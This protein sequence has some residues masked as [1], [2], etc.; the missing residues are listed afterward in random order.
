MHYCKTL[1]FN[2]FSPQQNINISS[3][4]INFRNQQLLRCPQNYYFSVSSKLIRK[5][6]TVAH[7]LA[8]Q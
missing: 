1:P 5:P 8:D 7:F 6:K 4:Y 3:L 2:F